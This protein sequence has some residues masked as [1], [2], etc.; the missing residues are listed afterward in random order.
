MA[1]G[2][3]AQTAAVS[4]DSLT[5]AMRQQAFELDQQH[6][7]RLTGNQF[8]NWGGLGEKWIA[9]NGGWF[10]VTPDGSLYQWD[11]NATQASGEMVA[12]LSAAF[13][14]DLSLLTDAPAAEPDLAALDLSLALQSTTS[15]FL[16][17]GG[18]QEKWLMGRLGTWYFITP[19]GLM[20]EWNRGAGADGNVVADVGVSV[21]ANLTLLTEASTRSIDALFAE[22]GSNPDQI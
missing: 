13:H 2:Q 5:P 6:Q 18:R 14:A 22:S 11:G 17:W 1:A 16:N 12:Q 7:L 20:Y 9:G 21:Y 15:D 10:F 3:A 4:A 8:E 19:D